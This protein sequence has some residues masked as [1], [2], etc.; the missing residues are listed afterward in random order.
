MQILQR[1][2]PTQLAQP[3]QPE[4]R[5]QED[6]RHGARAFLASLVVPTG[7][8]LWNLG[9]TRTSAD[10]AAPLQTVLAQLP[11]MARD[12]WV[13]DNLNT[14]WSLDVCRL[15][16]SW[17]GL[18]WPPKALERGSQRRAFLRDPTPKH[19][20]H[21]TPTHG[22]WLH[23]V[24]LGFSVLARRFLKRGDFCSPTDFE[25]RLADYLDS[26]PYPSRPS[27]PLDVYGATLGARHALQSHP[28]PTAAGT[29]LVEP[30]PPTV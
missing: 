23:Q 11:E 28:T 24:E 4:K 14:H 27:L 3:G 18:P 8:V 26:L 16:A 17:C 29:G 13:L 25:T 1:K 30:P 2:Y 9:P 12:D 10:F 7:Q 19:V 15:V 22:S 5:E 20:C 6:I 21:C